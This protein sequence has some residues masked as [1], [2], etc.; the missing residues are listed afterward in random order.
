[1]AR[2]INLPK[3]GQTMEE[4][5][6][7][8]CLVKVGAEVK[9][10]D[11][12]FEIETDKA[13]LEMES[14]ASGF[15]KFILVQ[16][17]QTLPV[18]TP[19]LVLGE[20]DEQVPMSFVEALTGG[21]GPAAGT[22]VTPAAQMP[23]TILPPAVEPEPARPVGKMMVSPRAKKMAEELGVNL[24]MVKGT[25]PAGKITEADIRSAAEAKPTGV[26]QSPV[27]RASSPRFEGGT[28]SPQAT[29]PGRQEKSC[30]DARPTL[31]T[32]A[33]AKLGA[34]VPVNRLQRITAERMLKSKREIP[35]FYLT[36]RV[37]MTD[38]VACRAKI[39]EAGGIKVAFND[40]IMKAVATGLEKYPMM[41]GQLVSDAIKLADAIHVGLAISVPDGLVAPLVKDVNKKDVRQI[42]RDSQALIE[43]TRN[44]KLD[45]SDLEGGCI[46]VSNLGAFG[47]E[48]FI[49]IV[50]PGQCSIL[51]IGRIADTCVPDNGNILVRRL[52]NMTLSV[53]H[54]VTNGA[55][56]AQF[57]DFV[58]KTLENP[59]EFTI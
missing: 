11:V 59:K 28:P 24:A 35:C 1:M 56:A 22:D 27:S 50:V 44:D 17:N 43:R 13:T 55:Y 37:D 31:T 21:V 38:L 18:G 16:A 46:T 42:A 58:K 45:L 4:G 26:A 49:P 47:I 7:V 57:L 15:V 39:N 6:V 30:G 48:S 33:E 2:E 34:T 36:V 40:F 10:G 54:K 29:V 53:D 5:T 3:M 23:T 41:T 20:K 19:L 25:G 12:I 52:M 9:K 14:S 51:G 32:A 8:N